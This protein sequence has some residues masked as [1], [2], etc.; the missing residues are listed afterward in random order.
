MGEVKP[1]ENVSAPV[2]AVNQYFRRLNY[3][4]ANN[5]VPSGWYTLP[6]IGLA[7]TGIGAA[8]SAPVATTATMAGGWLGDKVVNK[9]MKFATGKSW[10]ENMHDW[11]GL[12]KE[13]AEIT[14]PGMWIGGY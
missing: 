8:M 1:A 14:N 4:L 12:D 7:A 3:D 11:T 6:A 13:P 2:N 10:A 5:K 9:G